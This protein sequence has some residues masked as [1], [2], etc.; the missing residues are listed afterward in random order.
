MILPTQGQTILAHTVDTNKYSRHLKNTS[1]VRSVTNEEKREG[2]KKINKGDEITVL[3]FPLYL[4]LT[5]KSRDFDGKKKR[6]WYLNY[7]LNNEFGIG[8]YLKVNLENE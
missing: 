6:K 7:L 1:R 8:I 4:K 5:P 2:I 3:I